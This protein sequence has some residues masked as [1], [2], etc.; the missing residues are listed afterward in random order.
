MDFSERRL[1]E[2]HANFARNVASARELALAPF[3][4]R[5]SANMPSCFDFCDAEPLRVKR[6]LLPPRLSP[7]STEGRDRSRCREMN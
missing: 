5:H 2:L 4:S 3:V 1:Y 7:W 6:R